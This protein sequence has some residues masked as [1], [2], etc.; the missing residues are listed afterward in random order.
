M[1]PFLTR[2]SF[3]HWR[4]LTW[5]SIRDIYSA[6]LCA[7]RMPDWLSGNLPLHQRFL[8]YRKEGGP[9]DYLDDK[10]WLHNPIHSK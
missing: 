7:A 10:V 6:H 9:F 8:D 5:Q 3:R 1:T 4:E 2:R